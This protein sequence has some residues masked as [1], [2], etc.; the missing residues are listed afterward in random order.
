MILTSIVS[1]LSLGLPAPPEAALKQY[2]L[3]N[4]DQLENRM[5]MA[6]APLA[7]N[8]EPLKGY[9]APSG[10]YNPQFFSWV[11]TADRSTVGVVAA[12]KAG[13]AVD[14]VWVDWNRN[15]KFEPA[16]LAKLSEGSQSR[17][18]ES[19]KVFVYSKPPRGQGGP[20]YVKITLHSTSMITFAP[21]AVMRGEVQFAG[22]AMPVALIDANCNGVFGDNPAQGRGD[23]FLLDTQGTGTLKGAALYTFNTLIQ[24]SDGKFW[25]PLATKDGRQISFD[26]DA[27][28][29]G[30]IEFQGGELQTLRTVGRQ[31]SI[32]IR[33]VDGKVV[34]P[35]GRYGIGVAL[36]SVKD[37]AGERWSYSLAGGKVAEF[38][39]SP[40]TK[41]AMELGG[42]LKLQLRSTQFGAIRSFSMSL[43][44]KCG[45][46]VQGLYDSKGKRPD[47]PQLVIRD[48]EGKVVKTMPFAYG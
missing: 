18:S 33:P 28:P 13:G 45:A 11:Q 30:E 20:I 7:S 1:A 10:A 3:V 25:K 39:V 19:G 21:T 9:A 48:S 5:P 34:L 22:K 4:R 31:G 24:S 29:T 12:S 36:L 26:L 46:N 44:D 17:N 41:S 38:E 15:S 37:E 40:G 16:E 35:A 23:S 14:R 27:S 2:L 6:Y 47:P 32:D 42:P 8:S 43:L